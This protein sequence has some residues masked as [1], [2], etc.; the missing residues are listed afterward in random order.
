M[1]APKAS[2]DPLL[3][4]PLRSFVA[5]YENFLKVHL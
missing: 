2:T 4:I 3:H 1:D 5:S